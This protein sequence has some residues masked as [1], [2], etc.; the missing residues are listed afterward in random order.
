[1]AAAPAGR[2]SLHPLSPTSISLYSRPTTEILTPQLIDLCVHEFFERMYTT[3]PVL[4][5]GW[6]LQRVSEISQDSE[7]YCI[8]GALCVFMIS[9]SWSL[10]RAIPTVPSIG[11]QH[12]MLVCSRIIEDVKNVR[13]QID[14]AENPRTCTVLTS[15]FLSGALFDIERTNASW[16]YLQEA[17][18][19]SKMLQIHIEETY[20]SDIV[21]DTM[22]R[23][24]FWVLFISER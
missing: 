23:R 4:H 14:Y 24:I 15:F 17:I 7:S 11:K 9:R 12:A 2:D 6:L 5:R 22:N 3:V 1:M 8:V 18:T 20:G 19:F 10:L 16:F 13:N 21:L